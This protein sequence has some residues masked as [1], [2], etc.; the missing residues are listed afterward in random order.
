MNGVKKGLSSRYRKTFSSTRAIDIYQGFQIFIVHVLYITGRFLN[1]V[2]PVVR[3]L[4][5]PIKRN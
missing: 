4:H 2:V 3:D 1:R 5:D